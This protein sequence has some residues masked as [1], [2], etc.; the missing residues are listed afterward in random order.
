M[1]N[2]NLVDYFSLV[3]LQHDVEG[4]AYYT[5]EFIAQAP[6]YTRHALSTV[7]IGNGTEQEQASFF[8]YSECVFPY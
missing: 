8:N 5:F 1:M 3:L 6:N 4:K 2:M 7:C